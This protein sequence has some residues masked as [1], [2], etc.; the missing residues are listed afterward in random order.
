MIE[1][2]SKTQYWDFQ[3]RNNSTYNVHCCASLKS[4]C[5]DVDLGVSASLV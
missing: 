4:C 1:L 2:N 5:R 3:S